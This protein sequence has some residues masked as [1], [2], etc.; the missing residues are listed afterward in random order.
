M[1]E[2]GR[3]DVTYASSHRIVRE[4]YHAETDKSKRPKI[5]GM[6]AS[7]VDAKVDVRQAAKYDPGLRQ[8]TQQMLT[9]TGNSRICYTARL[10]QPQIWHCSSK[11]S[12]APQRRWRFIVASGHQSRPRCTRG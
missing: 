8:F 1:S 7:P 12:A 9:R 5:F 4:F 11:R 6:T 10:L 2:I 3:G